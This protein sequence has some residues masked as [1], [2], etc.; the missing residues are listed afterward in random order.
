MVTKGG[1]LAVLLLSSLIAAPGPARSDGER[2]TGYQDSAQDRPQDRAPN[3]LATSPRVQSADPPTRI[4]PRFHVGE[5]LVFEVKFKSFP[6]YATV[7][8]ITMEYLGPQTDPQIQGFDPQQRPPSAEPPT[9]LRG[10]AI[11]K[12]VVTSLLGIDINNRYE[13]LVDSN[14]F[15]ALVSLEEAHESKRHLIATSIFDREN[16]KITFTQTDA[17]RGG[18]PLQ[19]KTLAW[20]KGVLDILSCFYFI[21]LQ[22]MKAGQM[23]NLPVNRNGETFVFQIAIEKQEKISTEQGKVRAW[24]LK[25]NVFGPGQMFARQG[26]MW[27]WLCDGEEHVPLRL[28]AKTSGSTIVANLTQSDRPCPKVGKGP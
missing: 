22:K 7:G 23:L 8:E 15:S 17:S 2:S 20:R 25:P 13:T 1:L 27:V 24:R 18:A 11:S 26:Q 9:H 3:R 21:R 19:S 12:G 28:L 14:D 16:Q 5:K 10:Q 4:I 6:I